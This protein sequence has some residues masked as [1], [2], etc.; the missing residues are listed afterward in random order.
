MKCLDFPVKYIGQTGRTFNIRY[1]EHIQA[2]RSNHNS[3][4]NASRI[5]NTGHAYGSITDAMGVIH[6]GRKGK[7]LNSLEKYHIYKISKDELH[8]NDTNFEAHNPIFQ[9]THEL[10]DR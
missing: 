3:T 8:M 5:L 1:K 10:Y 4:G 7:H 2:I 6:T 9:V